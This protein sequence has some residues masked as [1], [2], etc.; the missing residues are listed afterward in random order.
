[1]V[2]SSLLSGI[3][4]TALFTLEVLDVVLDANDCPVIAISFLILDPLPSL[5]SHHNHPQNGD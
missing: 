1:M 5:T 2:G 3:Y 4:V